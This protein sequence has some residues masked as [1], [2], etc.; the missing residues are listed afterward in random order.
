MNEIKS[1]TEWL[2]ND[3]LNEIKVNSE[4][5]DLSGISSKTTG[6]PYSVYFAVGVS[7]KN[8]KIYIKD[9]NTYKGISLKEGSDDKDIQ[10]FIDKNKDIII[11]YWNYKISTKKL[12]DGIDKV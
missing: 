6:L 7:P 2:Q 3:K 8:P 1:F 4:Y 10:E 11:K 5:Y 9:N 12:I